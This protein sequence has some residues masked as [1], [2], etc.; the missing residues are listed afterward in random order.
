MSRPKIT[1]KQFR[2]AALAIAR[3]Q[4]DRIDLLPHPTVSPIDGGAFVEVAVFVTDEEA[5]LPKP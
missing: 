1:D 2:A 4:P 5:W 3:T